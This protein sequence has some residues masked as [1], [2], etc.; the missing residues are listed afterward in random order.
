MAN[1][2][3]MNNPMTTAG[4]VIQ[5]G[6]SGAP[7]RLALGTAGQ[8]LKVNAGATALEYGDES[9]GSGT[10]ITYARK[11]ADQSSTSTTKADVTDLTFAVSAST[12]YRYRFCVFFTTSA[13]TEGLR[14]SVNGPTG[15]YRFGGYLPVAAP[16][17]GGN[18]AMFASG[19]GTE[20]AA[21]N[22]T[23]GV[24]GT[25][26]MAVIEGV[27]R[28]GGTGGTLALRFWA[29]TGGAASVTI[30]EDSYGEISELA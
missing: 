7:A 8:I 6:A 9:G 14:L 5:G 10:T 3:L 19:G 21:F 13:T 22:T 2:P 27:A 11:T 24:G 20:S 23:S 29:E 15:T 28:I 26:A 16:A 4:D 25:A 17:G 12:N 18:A 1:V 30:L